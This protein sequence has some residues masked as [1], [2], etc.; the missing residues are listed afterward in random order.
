VKLGK[1]CELWYTTEAWNGTNI[2]GTG[3]AEAL[4][5]KDVKLACPNSEADVTTRGSRG[6]KLSAAILKEASIEF[7]LLLKP[8]DAFYTAIRN[9]WVNSDTTTITL[10]ILDGDP[11]TAGTEGLAGA[12]TVLDFTRDE[13]QENP[14]TFSV[15]CKPAQADFPP[16]WVIVES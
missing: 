6:Y 4:T 2:D 11:D 12:F 1:N 7:T 14:V 5:V 3:W 13:G 9:A 16:T 10:A 8:G 15:T